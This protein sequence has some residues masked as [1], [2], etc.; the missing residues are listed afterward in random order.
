MERGGVEPRRR[1]ADLDEVARDPVGVVTG[2]AG[3]LVKLELI[4]P[5]GGWLQTADFRLPG[6]AGQW[7][8]L[9]RGVAACSLERDTVA[10]EGGFAEHNSTVDMRGSEP[11]ELMG[12]FI[13]RRCVAKRSNG[14]GLW[15]SGGEARFARRRAREAVATATVANETRCDPPSLSVA[16]RWCG[17]R[18]PRRTHPRCRRRD[19]ECY[20]KRVVEPRGRA[21]ARTARSFSASRRG[22]GSSPGRRS[23]GSSRPGMRG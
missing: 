11:Q 23:G 8:V 22:R 7:A 10:I 2:V 4:M 3:V 12:I 15:K 5:P 14:C 16:R 19:A 21:A 1:A 18:N 17:R 9:R 20:W 6:T 13:P